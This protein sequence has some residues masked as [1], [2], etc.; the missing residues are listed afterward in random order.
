MWKKYAQLTSDETADLVSW[1]NLSA[2]A[3]DSTANANN[4][5]LS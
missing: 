1:W 4:G 2:D 5:T 3:K